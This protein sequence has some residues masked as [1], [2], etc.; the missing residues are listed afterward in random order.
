MSIRQRGA[1]GGIRMHG[2]AALAAAYVLSQF[3]RTFLAVLT[4]LAGA[5]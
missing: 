3:Y 1:D 5:R 4:P 2:L